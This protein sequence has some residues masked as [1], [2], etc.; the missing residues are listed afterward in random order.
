VALRGK[1][2]PK[3]RVQKGLDQGHPRHL[4]PGF[5]PQVSKSGCFGRAVKRLGLLAAAAHRLVW[6]QSTHVDGDIC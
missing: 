6:H 1:S 3:T 5:R 2:N 4:S